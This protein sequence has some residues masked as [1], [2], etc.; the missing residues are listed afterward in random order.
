MSFRSA[1][2]F[3]ACVCCLSLIGGVSAANSRTLTQSLAASLNLNTS[4]TPI[5]INATTTGKYARFLVVGGKLARCCSRQSGR[6][7]AF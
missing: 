3:A 7:R 4:D 6:N 5:T 2:F 1:A